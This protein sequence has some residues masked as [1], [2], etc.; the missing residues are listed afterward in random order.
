MD[1]L[2]SYEWPGNVRELE[3]AIERAVVVGKCNSIKVED[4]P[5]H[6]S[7]G[8]E[9]TDGD[10]R[11]CAMEKKYI[12]KILNESNWNISKSA[13]ILDIDRVTLYNKIYKYGLRTKN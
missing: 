2:V 5:F 6:V 8:I 12:L 10:R 9:P 11:L 7:N 3:N 13:Q 4:L 1:F